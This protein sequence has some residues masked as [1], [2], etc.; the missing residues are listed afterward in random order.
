MIK[1]LS[2]LL[3]VL[4]FTGC[5]L[6]KPEASRETDQLVGLLISRIDYSMTEQ[7][8]QKVFGTPT[9]D[10]TRV[11][12]VSFECVPGHLMMYAPFRDDSLDEPVHSVIGGFM[13]YRAIMDESGT[14]SSETVIEN[15]LYFPQHE[16]SL[17]DS[18]YVYKTPDDKYYVLLEP[19]T[20]HF[21]SEVGYGVKQYHEV[22][23][24][25]NS[26][27]TSISKLTFDYWV[28][29]YNM[30]QSI[31]LIASDKNHQVLDVQE[32]PVT[33]KPKEIIIPKATEYVLV[34]R[35]PVKNEPLVRE[36]ID[37]KTQAISWPVLA[38][39]GFIELLEVPIQ[40]E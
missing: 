9:M 27:T 36:V 5:Q 2:L 4:L 6:A 25:D 38:E 13:D 20:A 21:N 24:Y 15:T 32:Y 1:R 31:H 18:Y 23:N 12:A 39:S 30:E 19:T 16:T 37:P 7:A 8:G 33:D 11:S 29:P 14:T 35:T 40:F 34:E 28:K 17:T 10:G 26:S 22:K 3:I